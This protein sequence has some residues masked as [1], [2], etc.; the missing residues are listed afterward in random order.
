MSVWIPSIELPFRS[1]GPEPATITA[2][3]TGAAA[4]VGSASVPSSLRS[5]LGNVNTDSPTP[6]G[7]SGLRGSATAASMSMLSVHSAVT[8]C[9]GTSAHSS[10]PDS[11][12]RT[13]IV[14]P[15]RS[16]TPSAPVSSTATGTTTAPPG[17]HTSSVW[18]PP[19]SRS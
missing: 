15:A 7:G 12:S 16:I 6:S 13:F 9:A 8:F 18:R 2:T 4:A 1:V 5:P 10:H 3:G 17:I 11:E 19:A 14:T